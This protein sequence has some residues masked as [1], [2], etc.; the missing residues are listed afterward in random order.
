MAKDSV[1]VL[2]K[3]ISYLEEKGSYGLMLV[4]NMRAAK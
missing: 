4:D 1:D 3:A 2:A